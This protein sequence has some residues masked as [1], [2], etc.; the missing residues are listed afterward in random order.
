LDVFGFA[1]SRFE[2]PR[3]E[4]LV[5]HRAESAFGGL[6][7]VG[8]LLGFAAEQGGAEGIDGDLVRAGED[9][10]LAGDIGEIAADGAVGHEDADGVENDELGFE[11]AGEIGDGV[12]D[13]LVHTIAGASGD[14]HEVLH[15]E[16]GF[17]Q[18]MVFDDGDVDETV[19]LNGIGI[20]F[21]FLEGDSF[22]GHAAEL[23]FVEE[24][25]LGSRLFGGLL[26]AAAGE[27][28]LGGVA[29]VVTDDDAAR[30]GFEAH[31]DEGGNDIGVGIGGLFG[32]A[33]PTN[34]RFHPD[35]VALG[36]EA[37]HAAESVDG[38]AREAAGL[39]GDGGGLFG[40]G[41]VAGDAERRLRLRLQRGAGQETC[42]GERT[43]FEE[44]SSIQFSHHFCLESRVSRSAMS[45]AGSAGGAARMMA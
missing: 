45:G 9:S 36:D 33:V 22:N 42:R 1:M 27:G 11:E 14:A 26:D 41:F 28:A 4:G 29:G 17:T 18:A 37:L 8:D 21:P 23:A 40:R 6:D 25:D 5:V 20:H 3:G 43:G 19:G 15:A 38:L 35:D 16:G 31:L 2:G 12:V 44:R 32:S 10:I 13:V 34:V 30:A 24:E 7:D 39:L